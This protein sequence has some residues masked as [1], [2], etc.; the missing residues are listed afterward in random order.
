[1]RLALLDDNY[2]QF[3]SVSEALGEPD[4]LL[5]VGGNL[6]PETLISA[7]RKGIFPWYQDDS[8]IL[9]WS[10]SRRCLISPSKFHI[11]SSLRRELR[12][13][14]YSITSNV[15]FQDVVLACAKSRGDGGTWITEQMLNAYTQLRDLHIAHSV[16]VWNGGIL[17][18]GIY[19]VLS[20][21]IFCGESMFSA[22]SNSSKIALAHLCQ[23][24]DKVGVSWLDCQLQNDHLM[25]LG[26]EIM[27]REIFIEKLIQSKSFS[28]RWEFSSHNNWKW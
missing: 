7:Y 26:A 10:P 22:V 19:G 21:G 24:L 18:G 25:T 16:E 2:P 23:Y 9:W 17:V 28:H 15:C 13:R 11:S 8:P 20:G 4:G 6:D 5:A 12:Q 14:K 3:P 1:M 27:S